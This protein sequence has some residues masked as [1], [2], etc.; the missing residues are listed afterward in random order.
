MLPKEEIKK[1][2]ILKLCCQGDVIH[3]T[4]VINS[5]KLN[6]PQSQIDFLTSYWTASIVHQFGNLDSVIEVEYDLNKNFFFQLKFFY[7][8]YRKIRSGIYDIVLLAHRNNIYGVV[9]KLAGV[10]YRIGFDG[11]VFI[12]YPAEFDESQH[13][14]LRY[15]NILKSIGLEIT[16]PIPHIDLPKNY[17]ELKSEYNKE[18]KKIVLGVFPF[19]GVNP[20]T[21]MRI[22]RWDLEKYL[23]L[24]QNVYKQNKDI[25]I[26]IFE[27]RLNDEKIKN[28]SDLRGVIITG[29]FN[30][31]ALCS[32][33]ITNDTGAL[34]IAASYGI[35][36][37]SIFGPSD[38]DILAPLNE[39][40]LK[41]HHYVWKK[42]HCS[43]CWNPATSFNRKNKKYWKGN[44]FICN[45]GT[46]ECIEKITVSEVYN[47]LN[48]MLAKLRNGY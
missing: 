32:V 19:G 38:P 20:G 13:E 7:R 26:I 42:P 48:E 36:T 35:P 43:P 27:G 18:N 8:L 17:T 46:H 45:T 5:L 41:K 14:T 21:D 34:H 28:N 16:N 6:F 25:Q 24:C 33:F 9:L 4:P 31:I 30:A 37:L 11:T 29:D 15:I 40:G 22:K 3:L 39:P 23:S 10:K 1:I 44:T 47:V 12:N 2:L